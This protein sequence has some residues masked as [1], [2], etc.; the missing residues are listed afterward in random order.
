MSSL[1][2]W[3]RRLAANWITL[4]GAVFTTISG[5]ALALFLFVEMLVPGRNP[6]A[7]SFLIMG[8]AAMFAFGLLL[9]PVGF[10]HEG[11]DGVVFTP[12]A[13]P[14]LHPHRH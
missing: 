4:L 14:E 3:I 12:I 9:L 7:G 11:K 5:L 2:S 10:I 8:L 13:T 1:T 6:Y